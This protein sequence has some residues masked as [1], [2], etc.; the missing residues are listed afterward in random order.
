VIFGPQGS[1]V[2][3]VIDKIEHP[4]CCKLLVDLEW[5]AIK[6]A[7]SAESPTHAGVLAIGG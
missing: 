6:T 1:A 7:S 4:C 3:G 2:A 5:I